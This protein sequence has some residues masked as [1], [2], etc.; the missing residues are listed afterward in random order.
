MKY[1][2]QEI[3]DAINSYVPIRRASWRPNIYLIWT[4][5]DV[6]NE[7]TDGFHKLWKIGFMEKG[8]WIVI[9]EEPFFID[10]EWAVGFYGSV[11]S[12]DFEADDWE[13]FG[14]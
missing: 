14:S 13:I 5:P 7:Y 6:I 9:E 10:K 2:S 3:R 11:I 1:Y 4:R 8:D 12:E